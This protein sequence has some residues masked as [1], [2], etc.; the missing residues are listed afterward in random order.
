[1]KRLSFLLLIFI[2]SKAFSQSSAT[3]Y[4]DEKMNV[5]PESKAVIKGTGKIENGLFKVTAYY[6]KNHL[7]AIV[8]YSDSS[9]KQREGL[10]QYYYK[11]GHLQTQGLFQNGKREGTWIDKGASG[12]TFDSTI[13]Q[14]GKMIKET[15]FFYTD[16]SGKLVSFDDVAN[17]KF[18]TAE[19]NKYGGLVSFDS[20]DTDCHDLYFY[21]DTSAEFSSGSTSWMKIIQR[22]IMSNIEDLNSQDD[23]TLLIR[24]VIDENG[25]IRDV[26]ALNKKNSNLAKIMIPVISRAGKWK[27]A[28]QDGQKVKSAV[29]QPITISSQ[30]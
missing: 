16:Q 29:L 1:M 26:I 11:S 25:D 20:T 14:N 7:A 24:F 23:G 3:Y 4:F 22:T 5:V 10:Y 27:P 2:V 17:N 21:A 30:P 28:I 15:T 13:F 12:R 9:L 19:F 6:R 8:N 18:Y